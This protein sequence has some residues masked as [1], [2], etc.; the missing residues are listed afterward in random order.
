MT[1]DR[2]RQVR[3]VHA[4][5]NAPDDTRA[6]LTGLQTADGRVP[7]PP[8]ATTLETRLTDA[9]WR[10]RSSY[11]FDRRPLDLTDLSTLLRLAAGPQRRVRLSNGTEHVAGMAP[12]AG[13]LPSIDL[14]AVVRAGHPIPAGVHRYDPM[15]QDLQTVRTG[16]PDRALRSTLVQPEFADRAPVVLALAAR[17]D[18]TLGKYPIR[19]Y[20]TLH[21]DAGILAQN[22]YLT[23]TALDLACCAVAGFRDQALN[24]VLRLSDHAFGLL[25]FPVG[26]RSPGGRAAAQSAQ[27]PMTS[28]V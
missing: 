9:L 15:A 12:S 3:A 14:Y 28:T 26:H 10:R 17:L 21:V 11:S 16:D 25:L 19:H 6:D 13:G 5:L 8:A 18:A 23:V 1:E 24:E 20:R 22:L 4:H 27:V 7:L 2:V